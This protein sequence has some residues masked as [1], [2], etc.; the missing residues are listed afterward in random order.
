[1]KKLLCFI[2]IISAVNYNFAQGKIVKAESAETLFGKVTESITFETHT[3]KE[4]TS[5]AGDIV[6]FKLEKKY[7]SILD[8]NRSI[9]FTN[10]ATLKVLDQDVYH[11]FSTNILN[12]LLMKAVV[13]KV[14][15][16]NRGKI[17]SITA[18]QY[19][20]ELSIPC[21]PFCKVESIITPT[22]PVIR[23]AELENR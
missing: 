7:L 5:K 14:Y 17:F 1:M 10:S 12:E 4:L 15:L 16:E 23:K 18:G 19:T 2:V 13:E 6:M 20:L 8:E 3:L 22:I 9:L 11:A 21:P